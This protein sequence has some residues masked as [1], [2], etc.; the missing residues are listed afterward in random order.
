MADNQIELLLKVTTENTQAI[1]KLRADVEQL[2]NTASTAVSSNAKLE[3]SLVSLGNEAEKMGKKTK[4]ATDALLNIRNLYFASFL[5]NQI[6]NSIQMV[7][8]ALIG[9]TYGATQWN[10]EIENV[11]VQFGFTNKETVGLELSLKNVGRG[12]GDVDQGLRMFTL[13]MY[14]AGK[15]TGYGADA[16]KMLGYSAAE[17]RRIGLLPTGESLNILIERMRELET[18]A[19][20]NT[21]AVK[22]F[23]RSAVSMMPVVEEGLAAGRAQAELFESALTDLEQYVSGRALFSFREFSRS[24]E[25]LGHHFGL[26]SSEML[27]PMAHATAS[28]AQGMSASIKEAFPIIEDELGK[29]R[30]WWDKLADG[31]KNAYAEYTKWATAG[32]YAG[33]VKDIKDEAV[34]MMKEKL[35]YK[36]FPGQTGPSEQEVQNEVAAYVKQRVHDLINNNFTGTKTVGPG[37]YPGEASGGL[38]RGESGGPMSSLDDIE[39]VDAAFDTALSKIQARV[40]LKVYTIKDALDALIQLM[41]KAETQDQLDRLYAVMEKYNSIGGNVE[42]PFY[43]KYPGAGRMTSV[44]DTVAYRDFKF[45]SYPSKAEGTFDMS[46]TGDKRDKAAREAMMKTQTDEQMIENLGLANDKTAKLVFTLENYNEV[47]ANATDS[48]GLIHEALLMWGAGLTVVRENLYLGGDALYDFAYRLGTSLTSTLDNFFQDMLASAHNG[49]IKLASEWKKLIAALIDMTQREMMTSLSKA[50]SKMILGGMASG[51][52]G[53]GFMSFVL[54]IVSLALGAINPFLGIAAGFGGKM[55]GS[56]FGGGG[57]ESGST[58]LWNPETGGFASDP[59]P[60]TYGGGSNQAATINL[61]VNG[62]YFDTEDLMQLAATKLA[63]ALNRTQAEGSAR[64]YL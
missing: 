51:G 33:K 13:R 9:V 64:G 4:Q 32:Y 8:E 31:I 14:E 62:G 3:Q 35:A 6:Q 56:N 60:I 59:N 25:A 21:I 53:G 15:G 2:G 11:Q 50:F 57:L 52:G 18:T 34:N 24:V 7:G 27:G 45:G 39:A 26:V 49:T 55:I 22:L 47:I 5:F 38:F 44:P 58:D 42:N 37:I 40:Q 63:P 43:G 19:E 30:M 29:Q 20:R 48:T 10:K 23:G 28:L 1:D 46:L 16:M 12:I 61:T 36:M 17:A 54:P 41:Q